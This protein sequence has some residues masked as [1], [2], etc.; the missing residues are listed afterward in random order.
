M[1][2]TLDELR[3]FAVAARTGSLGAAA[4]SLALSQPTVS[5]RI[6]R[7]E[8]KLGTR[9][10]VRGPRGVQLSPDGTR[11]LPYAIRCV[12]LA[13]EAMRAARADSG[14]AT[15]TLAGHGMFSPLIGRAVELL[16][17]FRVQLRTRDAHSDQ[18]VQLLTDQQVDAGIV[19]EVPRPPSVTLRRLLTTPAVAVTAPGHPL[20]A[21]RQ[22][23]VADLAA[24]AVAA[25]AAGPGANRF[26]DLLAHAQL[27]QHALRI[28]ATAE[29][30][31]HLARHQGHVAVVFHVSVA[32]DLAAGHLAQLPVTDLPRWTLDLFLAYRTADRDRPEITALRRLS[33][34]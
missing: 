32:D 14:T 15:F 33:R 11:L 21:R 1:S 8:A 17:E 34:Q 16:D 5:E 23:K 12:E 24:H 20:A 28:T 2:I 26:F 9:L 3:V 29:T 13:D 6:A 19:V 22:L 18:I 4:R 25:N 7:L 10:L 31:T 30:A 27:P